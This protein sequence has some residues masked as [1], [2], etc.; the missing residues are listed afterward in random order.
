MVSGWL[1]M[2]YDNITTRARLDLR[3]TRCAKLEGRL[4]SSDWPL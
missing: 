4:R 1:N 2:S 3:M